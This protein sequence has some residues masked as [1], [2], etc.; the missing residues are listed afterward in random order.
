MKRYLLL[1]MFL[2]YSCATADPT[3]VRKEQKLVAEKIIKDGK[4]YFRFYDG[5]VLNVDIDLFY[6]TKE[7]TTIEVVWRRKQK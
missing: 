3:V 7:H 6:A 5:S 4:H 1:L 2:T